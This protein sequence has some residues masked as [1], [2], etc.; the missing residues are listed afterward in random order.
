MQGDHGLVAKPPKEARQQDGLAASSVTVQ[1]VDHGDAARPA[2]IIVWGPG[3][4]H[5]PALGFAVVMAAGLNLCFRQSW[6]A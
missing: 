6:V 2:E 1:L 4:D 3:E 5:S